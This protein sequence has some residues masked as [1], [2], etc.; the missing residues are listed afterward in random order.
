MAGPDGNFRL[1]HDNRGLGSIFVRVRGHRGA[2]GSVRACCRGRRR[3]RLNSPGPVGG[4]SCPR[5]GWTTAGPHG[6]RRSR[7]LALAA[8]LSAWAVPP[9]LLTLEEQ[10]DK[11]ERLILEGDRSAAL[12]LL[13]EIAAGHAREIERRH[14][15]R[16]G[17]LVPACEGR[18]ASPNTMAQAANSA[19][20]YL[21]DSGGAGAHYRAAVQMIADLAPRGGRPP[22]PWFRA[23]TANS[24]RGS[25]SSGTRS[26]RGFADPLK[27]G[28]HGPEMVVVPAGRF[29][30]GCPAEDH[31]CGRTGKPIRSVSIAAFAMARH[32]TTFAEWDACVAAKACR[33]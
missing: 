2:T 14:Q 13:D 6:W 1:V 17:F 10:L 5:P 22:V 9:P 20:R 24:G 15:G 27:S 23:S 8:S 7:R 16:R 31:R 25:K 18:R 11:A 26:S 19:M 33:G 28:G 32:E 4:P 12:S 29:Y 30:M 3:W 21:A